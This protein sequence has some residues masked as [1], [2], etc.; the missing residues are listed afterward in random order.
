MLETPTSP[1]APYGSRRPPAPSS[2][3]ASW[4]SRN[5]SPPPL[6][7][8]RHDPQ[9]GHVERSA[10]YGVQEHPRIDLGP[11]GQ[12]DG[13]GDGV[14]QAY[15]PVVG[16]A[17]G[18]AC[19]RARR[20]RARRAVRWWTSAPTLGPRAASGPP[21]SSHVGPSPTSVARTARL[22]S[23]LQFFPVDI[24]PVAH[25]RAPPKS[26][27]R[28]VRSGRGVGLEPPGLVVGARSGP[29]RGSGG[30]TR[31]VGQ[32]T[33]QLAP[34]ADIVGVLLARG[35]RRARADTWRFHTCRPLWK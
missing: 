6:W 29:R 16:D 18:R 7:C 15:H 31:Q 20:R 12:C 2:W 11:V 34:L 14:G 23:V 8:L 26:V 10:L 33:A 13:L 3:R 35:P 27:E 24:G 22:S 30:S 1:S 17:S 25:P 9:V 19:R 32:C 5:R 4:T 28:T 21:R